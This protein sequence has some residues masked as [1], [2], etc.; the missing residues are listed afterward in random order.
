VGGV[1]ALRRSEFSLVAGLSVL[2]SLFCHATCRI[3]ATSVSG[4]RAKHES[5]QRD[6]GGRTS[7]NL[8]RPIQS[9]APLLKTCNRSRSYARSQSIV[10]V[11]RAAAG[12]IVKMHSGRAR[13][14]ERPERAI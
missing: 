11:R 7:G 13:E 14:R 6:V 12:E 9:P 2:I 1:K 5:R 8:R 4:S 10:S 3:C